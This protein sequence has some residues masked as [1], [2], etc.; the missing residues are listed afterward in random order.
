MKY[1]NYL[2]I[3]FLFLASFSTASAQEDTDLVEVYGL[4]VARNDDGLFQQI[5]FVA[6]AIKGTSRG[7]YSNYEGVYSIV[8]QKGQT[9]II[10]ALGFEDKEIVIPTDIVGFYHSLSIE[11]KEEPIPLNQVTV[12]PWPDR[13]NLA[14]EFLGMKPS[15]SMKL[16]AIAKENL[17]RK[18]LIAIAA[19]TNPDGKESASY[20]L[21]KQTSSYAYTG[22]LAPQNIFNP[23]AWGRFIKKIKKKE[24]SAKEKKILDMM[25]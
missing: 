13:N 8:A 10:T 6:I 5:P 19:N 15:N 25:E 20:Y 4:V 1:T 18:Q 11:I 12:F 16:E 7:T 21:R 24:L 23:L 22:Q 9:I 3:I 17:E 14:A 2:V